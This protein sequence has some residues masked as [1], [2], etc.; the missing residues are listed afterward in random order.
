MVGFPH[1]VTKMSILLLIYIKI[2]LVAYFIKN[3]IYIL[4]L[5]L[6]HGEPMLTF[7]G[8]KFSCCL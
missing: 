4:M 5:C 6:I 7:A 1:V 3:R 2:Y 8:F